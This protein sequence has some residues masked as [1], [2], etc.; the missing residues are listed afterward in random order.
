MY[1][2]WQ[3][4]VCSGLIIFV[5]LWCTEQKGPVFVTIFSPLGTVLV[6]FQAYFLLGERMHMGRYNQLITKVYAH[7]RR[8]PH[9]QTWIG[10]P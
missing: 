10:I 8:Y 3:G 1:D 7:V 9:T 6:G 2:K 4:L 5:Q